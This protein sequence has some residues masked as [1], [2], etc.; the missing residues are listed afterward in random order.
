[1][2]IAFKQAVT[3]I[4]EKKDYIFHAQK[5]TQQI[6]HSIPKK[7][8]LLLIKILI[9]IPSFSTPLRFVLRV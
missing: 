5:T 3:E 7:T 8:L 2:L 4:A 1:M 6:H 9:P